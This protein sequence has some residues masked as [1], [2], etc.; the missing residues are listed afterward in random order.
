[1]E[2][3]LLRRAIRI[4]VFACLGGVVFAQGMRAPLEAHQDALLLEVR[5]LRAEVHQ[6]MSAGIRTQ[7]LVARLQLQEQRVLTAARQLAE[8]QS[9]LA[10]LQGRIAGERLRVRQL[11]EAAARA[12][13]QGRAAF[14]Q[15]LVE[16]G[17]QIEQQQSQEFHLQT[18]ERELQRTLS[19]EQ[20]R[21]TELNERLDAL[22]RALPGATKGESL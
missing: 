9:A 13:G 16:A 2:S 5:A 4:G 10:A 19:D 20:A 3:P 8:A 1:M 22:E 11:E 15:A 14:Q 6:I 21:W 7:L 12:T 17:T 18:R